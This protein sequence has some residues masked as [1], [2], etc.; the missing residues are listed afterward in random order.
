MRRSLLH[1]ALAA[2]LL[3]LI[4]VQAGRL[5]RRSGLELDLGGNAPSTLSQGTL[6]FL[7][8]FQRNLS[9]TYFVTSPARL[10]SHLRQLEEEVRAMLEA[11]QDRAP[12]RIE[13]R[14][15]DPQLSN[16]AGIAYA[17]SKK[18]SPFRVR[19]ILRDAHSEEQIWSSLVLACEGYPEVL[20]Q[21]VESSHLLEELIVEHL[22]ALA[23]PPQP[24]FAVAAP[25]SFQLLPRHLSQYG[26]VLE[27]GF[28]HDPAAP[29]D[30]EVFFWIQPSEC[31]PAHLRRLQRLVDAGR[32]V[33]L[34]GSAYAVDY[35]RGGDG[36]LQ[37]RAVPLS[38][39]WEQALQPW[40]LQ[41][42]P[43]LLMDRATGPV[44]VLV[45]GERRQVEAPFHLRCSPAFRDMKRFAAPA[46]GALGF[47]A[48]SPLQLDTQ[49]ARAAGFQAE[50]AATTTENAWALPLPQGEFTD[51]DLAPQMAVGKQTLMVLLDPDD[52]WKGQVLVLASATPFQDEMFDQ[53]GY[54]HVVF[55]RDLART[56]ATPQRLVRLRVERPAP[57]AV[58]PLSGAQRLW[59]RC[60]AVFALPAV[61]VALGLRRYLGAGQQRLPLAQ[62]RI[63]LA[64]GGAL[65]AVIVSVWLAGRLGPAQ[66][67][68]T[69][70]Q[71]NTPAPLT[72]Q[73]LGAHR[74]GLRAELV[75]TEG[76]ELP[77]AF[78]FTEYKVRALLSDIALRITRPEEG[79]A[80]EQAWAR[81]LRPFETQRVLHDTVA[82]QVVWSGLRL[83]EAGRAEVI[84]RL[85][86]SDHL[87]FLVAAA[88][89]RLEQG[90]APRVAV[91]AEWPRLSPAEALED[92]QRQGLSPPSGADVYS[93][94]KSL[95]GDYGYEVA[96]VNPQEPHLPEG[97]DVVLWFQPRRDAGRL[98]LL[99]GRHLAQGG[100]AI[101]ALQHFNIQ[102][103]Q[104]R[105]AGFQTVYWPQP[106]FQDLDR[107]L[108]LLGLEQAR[109]VL[110]DRT[111]HHLALDTQVNRTAVREHDPQ[112]VALPFLI[113]A[114]ATHFSPTSEITRQLGDLL[115][116][117]GNRFSLDPSRLQAL[118]LDHQVLVATSEKSWS[119]PWQGGWLPP[120]VFSPAAYLNG[121]Q[122]LVV[123]LQGVFPPVEFGEDGKPALLPASPSQPPG[124][125]LLIGCSEMFKN[126]YLYAPGFQ[127]A[128]FLLNAVARAAYGPELAAL[129]AR[130]RAARGF[131]FRS[132][133][134]KLFWRGFAV[135][136]GPLLILFFGLYRYGRRGRPLHWAR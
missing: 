44:P 71:L 97:V 87:E 11:L 15:I 42:I 120:E 18:V 56:F 25:P 13:F 36:Q 128:Q 50:I 1:T 68:L 29:I 51:A 72:R 41:P 49:R 33:V 99:L 77:P 24:T 104:Y 135:A 46:R 67:D 101:V 21:G 19:R 122:P 92:F 12:G 107:Y 31:S 22:K 108:R 48:A 16:G 75:L 116:I 53:P 63:I 127:H 136:A 70:E 69:E 111:Q 52:P 126:E 88:L 121:A 40:G 91:V 81:G 117:W 131:E 7:D 85:G 118:G 123:S 27:V 93:Q 3:L 20:I 100:Q 134:A 64:A 83:E 124:S 32:S 112:E 98:I 90:R 125:L 35:G 106:Q 8:S 47:A 10:P 82:T 23:R 110:M 119:F 39:A 114:V 17:A 30:A 130:H 73:L 34:A 102:Q 76:A 9:I 37:Y 115:F 89:R 96:Y 55:L 58:P 45:A 105:G 43:D 109:E 86:T 5:L 66:L 79:A 84:P 103:R 62:A 94:V 133:E 61:L 26:P 80:Q 60:W 95:L 113:R 6:A 78:K 28:D 14:I 132:P 57:Q 4:A 129:Q 2:A 74:A 59:W 38:P 54:G 65:L